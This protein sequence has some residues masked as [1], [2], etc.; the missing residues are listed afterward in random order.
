M[1]AFK[2]YGVKTSEKANMLFRNWLTST[3]FRHHKLQ[4]WTSI[5]YC[6]AIRY[7]LIKTCQT[8][9]ELAKNH[10]WQYCPADLRMGIG[11]E[12]YLVPTRV[13]LVSWGSHSPCTLFT[14][15][16]VITSIPQMFV[17][18]M[19]HSHHWRFQQQVALDS[20]NNLLQET[21]FD[22]GR[23]KIS[24]LCSDP[25]LDKM[26]SEHCTSKS[27]HHV[28]QGSKIIP[29]PAGHWVSNWPSVGRRPPELT[30]I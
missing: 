15:T 12:M 14:Q 17:A 26:S 2:R 3:W 18:N 28:Y 29:S 19:Q 24:P 23:E 7:L 1:T 5:E 4:R 30:A 22:G 10:A 21:R 8:F 13:F 20:R 11:I 9:S 25:E 16:R 27:Q 6:N